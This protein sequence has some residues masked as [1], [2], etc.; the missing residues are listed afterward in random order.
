V[1]VFPSDKG[2]KCTVLGPA[3]PEDVNRFVSEIDLLSRLA[4]SK[5]PNRVGVSPSAE[6]I[7]AVS[8]IFIL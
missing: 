5:G 1:D 6:D 2:I 7:D 4:L 3:S 8:K